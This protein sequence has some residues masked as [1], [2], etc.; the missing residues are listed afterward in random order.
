[1]DA[2]RVRLETTCLFPT[3]IRPSGFD[4]ASAELF[5]FLPAFAADLSVRFRP[6]L[7]HSPGSTNASNFLAGI[8]SRSLSRPHFQGAVVTEG[9]LLDQ[10]RCAEGLLTPHGQ[11]AS[12]IAR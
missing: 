7:A 1:M 3:E 9:P 11:N 4:E 6:T 5:D 10:S 8:M 2:L 12:I